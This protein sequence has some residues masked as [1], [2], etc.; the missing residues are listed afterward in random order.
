ML[1]LFPMRIRQDANPQEWKQAQI[2][3]A[4]IVRH[5]TKSSEFYVM[6]DEDGKAWSMP[7]EDTF[8]LERF[9]DEVQPGDELTIRYD[10]WLS[11]RSVRSIEGYLDYEVAAQRSRES[12]RTDNYIYAAVLSVGVILMGYLVWQISKRHRLFPKR[13]K[14]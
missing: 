13:G 2:V 10:I 5:S 11:M 1:I 6:H 14:V 4:D 8:D 3:Y 7:D 12:A 9:R